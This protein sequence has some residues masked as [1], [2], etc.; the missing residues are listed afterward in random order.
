MA[1]RTRGRYRVKPNQ[2][3]TRDQ[4]DNLRAALH[5]GVAQDWLF[6]DFLTLNFGLCDYPDRAAEAFKAIRD[7]AT[8][9]FSYQERCGRMPPGEAFAFIWALEQKGDWP[10][11]HW[12]V[13]LPK[14]LR[15]GFLKMLPRWTLRAVGVV[16]PGFFHIGPADAQAINYLTKGCHPDHFIGA[17]HWRSPPGSQGQFSVKRAGASLNIARAARC[18]AG[19]PG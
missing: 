13:H 18:G 3:I 8:R 6:L 5:F 15:K 1:S 7:A 2:V 16:W 14:R 17:P 12:L 11:A 9:W 10:H 4:L 19:W